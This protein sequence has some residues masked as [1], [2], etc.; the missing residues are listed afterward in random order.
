V[1]LTHGDQV[2]RSIGVADMAC[3]LRLGRA[4]RASGELCF[5]VLDIMLAF[6]EASKAG[7]HVV[8]AS[9]CERPAA[10]PLPEVRFDA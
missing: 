8:L 5:H 7:Q 2:G 6:Q 4:P 10:L 9:R 3:A 1:R